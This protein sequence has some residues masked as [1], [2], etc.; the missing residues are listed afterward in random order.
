M[1]L[2]MDIHPGKLQKALVLY[3]ADVVSHHHL[4]ID[5]HLIFLII[6]VSICN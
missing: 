2:H 1:A 6:A 3:P 5:T 4:T